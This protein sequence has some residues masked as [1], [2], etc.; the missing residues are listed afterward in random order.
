M[1]YLHQ[2]AVQCEVILVLF[3]L[4]T[5]SIMW[6]PQ[7]SIIIY[8]M[9]MFVNAHLLHHTEHRIKKHIPLTFI[10]P[11]EHIPLGYLLTT[12]QWYKMYIAYVKTLLH[13]ISMFVALLC[14]PTVLVSNAL[15]SST[16]GPLLKL[17]NVCSDTKYR[18][19]VSVS[20]PR[21][22]LLHSRT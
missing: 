12:V 4:S 5:S 9:L 17:I 6:C 3:Y 19:Q 2:A 16:H 7:T 15:V 8:V 22:L 21:C 10:H 20:V 1:R 13:Y 11:C 14:P 18:V